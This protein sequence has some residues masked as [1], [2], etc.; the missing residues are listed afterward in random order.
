VTYTVTNYD[1][2]YKPYTYTY[3]GIE[4]RCVVSSIDDNG[5]VVATKYTP[6]ASITRFDP[7]APHQYD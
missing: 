5:K 3:Y 6:K 2:F 1:E 7:S 4:L